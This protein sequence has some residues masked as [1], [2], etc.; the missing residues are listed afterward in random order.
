MIL[1]K[2]TVASHEILIKYVKGSGF[3]LKIMEKK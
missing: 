1:E 3:Y 2:E